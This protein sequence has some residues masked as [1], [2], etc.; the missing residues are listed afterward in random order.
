MTC[1]ITVMVVFS[2]LAPA[3]YDSLTTTLTF[4]AGTD[5][6]RPSE[7]A[8]VNVAII[9]DSET[10]STESLTFNIAAVDV[11]RIRVEEG[12]SQKILFIE[13]NDGNA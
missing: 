10:E 1:F 9:D 4:R 13:D 11:D 2:P 3:D 12:R 8:C 5:G 6:S 7:A